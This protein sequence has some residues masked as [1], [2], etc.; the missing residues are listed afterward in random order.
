M[1]LSYILNVF[2]LLATY[3][4]LVANET[5]ARFVS[6]TTYVAQ[7]SKYE[8]EHSAYRHTMKRNAHKSAP[9]VSDSTYNS[10][11]RRQRDNDAYHD[12]EDSA[13]N[14]SMR[15]KGMH[16]EQQAEYPDRQQHHDYQQQPENKYNHENKY[17]HQQKEHYENKYDRKNEQYHPDDQYHRESQ[18]R[19]DDQYYHEDRYYHDKDSQ[20]K[21]YREPET[22]SYEERSPAEDANRRQ[23]PAYGERYR[24]DSPADQTMR[25][26]YQDQS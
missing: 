10:T 12:M 15:R 4:S 18:R 5:D 24:D 21:S 2:A 16:P 11:K 26:R 8:D 3:L 22:F 13:Y 19:R 6:E 7:G 20:G 17:Y 9:D 14:H 1:R 25:R 23:Q